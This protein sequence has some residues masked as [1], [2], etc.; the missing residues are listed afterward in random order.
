MALSAIADLATPRKTWGGLGGGHGRVEWPGPEGVARALSAPAGWAFREDH[1]KASPTHAKHGFRE[2]SPRFRGSAMTRLQARSPGM[3]MRPAPR[4]LADLHRVFSFQ[5]PYRVPAFLPRRH[6]WGLFVTPGVRSL[7]ARPQQLAALN[8]EAMRPLPKSKAAPQ[9]ERRATLPPSID[10]DSPCRAPVG[11]DR[12]VELA[13]E[14]RRFATGVAALPW[15]RAGVN[16]D[17]ATLVVTRQLIPPRRP[18][19]VSMRVG[20]P[21]AAFAGAGHL[22]ML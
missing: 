7:G 15:R 13:G 14:V 4:T 12:K 3:L 6:R 9:P 18:S 21:M 20:A 22:I 8:G 10:R 5:K 1:P 11:N 19:K 2:G 17:H 16:P